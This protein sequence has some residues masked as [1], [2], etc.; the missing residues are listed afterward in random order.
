MGREQESARAGGG[1]ADGLSRLGVHDFHHGLDEGPRGEVLARAALG[2]LGV[3]FQ[4]AFVD[5]ALGVDVQPD[6][7]LAV[8]QGDQALQLG[9]VL[10]LVLRLAENGRDQAG[11]GA[12]VLQDMQIL[13]F[14]VGAIL[15]SQAT[16]SS[17]Q[18][19]WRSSCPAWSSLRNPS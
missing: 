17:N 7:G 4:Q 3:L 14:Q 12:Q 1:V 13:G 6:P 18:Q 5:L 10:D 2:I 15:R 19:G 9:R 8:D 11:A 16:T